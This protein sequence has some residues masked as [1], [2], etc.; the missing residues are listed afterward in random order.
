MLTIFSNLAILVVSAI[1][2]GFV[3]T[4]VV[5]ANLGL[6]GTVYN[7]VGGVAGIFLF[8]QLDGIAQ[9]WLISKYPN[10]FGKKFS[11]RT[12]F[13]AR[14]KATFGLGG[15]AFLTPIFLSIPVGVFFA[16]DLT[17]NKKKVIY[18]M[19]LSCLFWGALFYVPY[20]VFK[21]DLAAWIKSF[22]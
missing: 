4:T 16:M 14:V 10:Q 21:I 19:L 8:V 3:A 20:Y 15:I 5:A 6:S 1:K 2:F 12:R 9:D 22:F 13:L 7:M 18:Y 11:K 17:T